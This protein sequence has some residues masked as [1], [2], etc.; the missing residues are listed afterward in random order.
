MIASL[1]EKHY[2]KRPDTADHDRWMNKVMRMAD[3]PRGVELVGLEDLPFP[4]IK[5][6]NVYVFPGVPSFLRMKFQAL[7]PRLREVWRHNF[8]RDF[9]A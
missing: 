2:E 4:V 7:K 6:R 1:L 5:V 3:L 8:P 9:E